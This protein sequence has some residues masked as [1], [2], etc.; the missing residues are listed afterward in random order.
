MKLRNP[1]LPLLPHQRHRQPVWQA[2][3]GANKGL[4]IARHTQA[5]EGPLKSNAA[6]RPR[7][8]QFVA[9]D[10]QAAGAPEAHKSRTNALSSSE[11]ERPDPKKPKLMEVGAGDELTDA[12]MEEPPVPRAS[13]QNLHPYTPVRQTRG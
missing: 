8:A 2:K 4:S 1:P 10:G 7:P 12:S 6:G 5:P 9:N 3:L 11:N 13:L